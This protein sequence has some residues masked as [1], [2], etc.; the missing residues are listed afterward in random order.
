MNSASGN[1]F[2]C[3]Y[4]LSSQTSMEMTR[5]QREWLNKFPF[6]GLSSFSIDQN[7]PHT[8]QVVKITR[9]SGLVVTSQQRNCH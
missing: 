5:L 9:N 6:A 3:N 4:I 2:P 7:K 8:E 1:H